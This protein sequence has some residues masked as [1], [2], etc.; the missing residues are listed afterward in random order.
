MKAKT[1]RFIQVLRDTQTALVREDL[2]SWRHEGICSAVECVLWKHSADEHL[3]NA[4][5]I[6]PLIF[7]SI[8]YRFCEHVDDIKMHAKLRKMEGWENGDYWLAPI[9]YDEDFMSYLI[10]AR[11]MLLELTALMLADGSIE[12]PPDV[13]SGDY[14][15]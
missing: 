3:K 11:I 6:M 12:T 10:T 4:K 2:D 5:E 15:V 14:W 9:S 8:E 13:V 1:A 7:P